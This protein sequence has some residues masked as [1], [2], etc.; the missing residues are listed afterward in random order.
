MAIE[1][2]AE[3]T[4]LEIQKV[5]VKRKASVIHFLRQ[6]RSELLLCALVAQIVVSPLADSY[7][8]RS[9]PGSIRAI[10]PAYRRQLHGKE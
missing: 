2:L 4:M 9:F 6:Y 5:Q 1:V 10:A 7:P 8:L 3:K